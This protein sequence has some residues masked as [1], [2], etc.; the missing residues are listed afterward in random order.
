[1][2][3]ESQKPRPAVTFTHLHQPSVPST[4]VWAL[5]WL[6]EH[7]LDGPMLFTA[8]GQTAGQGQRHKT[9]STHHGE[10]LSMSLALPVQSGWTPPIFNMAVALSF[11]ASLERLR[12]PHAAKTKVQIKWP[13]DILLTQ[14]GSNRKCAGML[15]ENVWRGAS[16]SATVVGV[17]VNVNSER[18]AS[19]F[20]AT[21]LR[22]AWGIT[23]QPSEAGQLLARDLMEQLAQPLHPP[24]VLR[25]FKGHLFGLGEN[26]HFD[27]GDQ[28]RKGVLSDVDEQGR[29]KFTWADGC[30]NE[31]LQS[32][33]VKW[34]FE[35]AGQ[36]RD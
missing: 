22:D 25:G 35:D 29:A 16:W 19:P 18:L 11:R 17:G 8:D 10:D 1:M 24:S 4:N 30:Q 36:N 33:D 2:A 20:H 14:E 34:R 15:V 32:G 28:T 23:L 3:N 31:W 27:V 12:P 6:K 7:G 26:R 13:N 21:S 9:W 5:S